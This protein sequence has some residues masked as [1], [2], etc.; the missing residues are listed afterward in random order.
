VDRQFPT[1]QDAAR[2]GAEC[3]HEAL[4]LW[5]RRGVVEQPFVLRQRFEYDGGRRGP[6]LFIGNINRSWRNYING[7]ARATDLVTGTCTSGRDAGRAVV[8]MQISAGR[9]ATAG[10]QLEVNRALRAVNVEVRFDANHNAGAAVPMAR[11]HQ[12]GEPAGAVP[13]MPYVASAEAGNERPAGLACA[14]QVPVAVDPQAQ[15]VTAQSLAEM[16]REIKIRFDAF[17]AAP[18]RAALDELSTL[19][20]AWHDGAADVDGAAPSK[21]GEFV[22]KLTAWLATKGESFVS[23]K[24][25]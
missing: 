9:G 11:P 15:P 23:H 22:T 21:A 17:K 19:I 10:N 1:P 24:S 3:L 5:L 18:S 7:N 12:A 14:A 6:M 16:A 13:P 25:G 4:N 20:G 2:A 8:T